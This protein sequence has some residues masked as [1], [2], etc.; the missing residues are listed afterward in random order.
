M[1]KGFE[2]GVLGMKEGEE[3]I[4]KIPSEEALK[5]AKHVQSL[6]GILYDASA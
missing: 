5:I 6:M 1:I 3:K 2:D 4:I